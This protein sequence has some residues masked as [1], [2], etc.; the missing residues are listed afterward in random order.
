MTDDSIMITGRENI[1]RAR[2]LARVNDRISYLEEMTS[3]Y[4]YIADSEEYNYLIK[5]RADL[6][7]EI[8]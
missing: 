8:A 6:E 5:L 4:P 3:R 2:W 7:R 1:E